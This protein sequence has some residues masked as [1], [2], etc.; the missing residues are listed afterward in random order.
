MSCPNCGTFFSSTRLIFLFLAMIIAFTA[1]LIVLPY[2]FFFVT[3][4][5]VLFGLR[6]VEKEVTRM[7]SKQFKCPKCGYSGKLLHIHH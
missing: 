4:I 5:V 6:T 1:S 2:E 7:D 3:A